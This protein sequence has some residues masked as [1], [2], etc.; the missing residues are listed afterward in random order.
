MTF[1]RH[2]TELQPYVSKAPEANKSKIRDAVTLYEDK[3][4]VN[5]RT[6][7]NATLL[8]IIYQ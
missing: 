5:F 8:F 2:L 4:I 6:A 1:K 7:F 3:N